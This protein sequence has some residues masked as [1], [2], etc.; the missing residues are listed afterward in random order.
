MVELPDQA[1]AIATQGRSFELRPTLMLNFGAHRMDCATNHPPIQWR[2]PSRV[3]ARININR[4]SLGRLP[5]SRIRGRP[6]ILSSQD[7][8]R[9]CR[10]KASVPSAAR[11][12]RRPLSGLKCKAAT[13]TILIE[14]QMPSARNNA[15]MTNSRSNNTHEA[16]G[17]PL[18]TA[19]K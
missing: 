2:V 13:I 17:V 16:A 14:I 5:F 4:Y 7:G 1:F 8:H 12:R 18:G 6:T 19:L 9:R 3:R 15:L 11:R 10:A